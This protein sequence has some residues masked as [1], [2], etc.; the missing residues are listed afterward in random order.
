[1]LEPN[2]IEGMKR[3]SSSKKDGDELSNRAGSLGCR[4]GN[5]FPVD[6]FFLMVD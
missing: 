5:G 1:M 2:E 4:P 6:L 3:A